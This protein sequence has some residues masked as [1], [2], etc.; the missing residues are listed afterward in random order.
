[1]RIPLKPSGYRSAR[2]ALSVRIRRKTDWRSRFASSKS[3]V[4]RVNVTTATW[5]LPAATSLKLSS[6]SFVFSNR[7]SLQ[8]KECGRRWWS[9]GDHGRQSIRGVW[10]LVLHRPQTLSHTRETIARNTPTRPITHSSMYSLTQSHTINTSPTWTV[11][12]PP[13]AAVGPSGD[14]SA[15]STHMASCVSA[16]SA[17]T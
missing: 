16:I 13:P 9:E 11:T 2:R 6:F 10:G 15:P 4:C 14:A 12:M 1:M 8:P 7:L 17:K 5:S 3:C